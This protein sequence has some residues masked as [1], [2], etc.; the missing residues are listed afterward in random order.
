MERRCSRCPGWIGHDASRRLASNYYTLFYTLQPY[1][2]AQIG[3]VKIQA[4]LDYFWG[5]WHKME[6][7]TGDVSLSA[8]AG[9][10][11]ATVDLGI[12]YFGGSIAY[13]AGDDPTTTDKKEGNSRWSAAVR[14]GIPA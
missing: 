8:L 10:V 5:D 3:P 1:A 2:I 12:F 13:V 9:W 4:E 11:D 7:G 14:I 6:S